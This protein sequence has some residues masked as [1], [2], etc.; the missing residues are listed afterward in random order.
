MLQI[1]AVK[2]A[3]ELCKYQEVSICSNPDCTNKLLL[4]SHDVRDLI[5][6]THLTDSVFGQPLDKSCRLL[7][8]KHYDFSYCFVFCHSITMELSR[9]VQSENTQNPG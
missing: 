4:A 9:N 5:V 6:Y 7:Y 2:Y 1:A 3:D 8:G